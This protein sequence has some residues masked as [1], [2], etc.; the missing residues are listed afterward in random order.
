MGVGVG[1]LPPRDSSSLSAAGFG[2]KRAPHTWILPPVSFCALGPRLGWGAL[3]QLR[4]KEV[5]TAWP[6]LCTET[7]PLP[8]HLH[9]AWSAGP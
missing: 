8:G 3:S 7:L 4:K 6:L 5:T 1:H 2:P 9:S